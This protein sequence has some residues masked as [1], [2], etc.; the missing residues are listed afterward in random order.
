MASIAELKNQV[1]SKAIDPSREYA[2]LVKRQASDCKRIKRLAT[3][4][5][6][7]AGSGVYSLVTERLEKAV[8]ELETAVKSLDEAGRRAVDYERSL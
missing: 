2:E 5:L 8:R 1:K 7:G 3:T 6:D 4:V